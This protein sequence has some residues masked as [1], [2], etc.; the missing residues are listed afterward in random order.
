ME[1]K[2]GVYVRLKQHANQE[3]NMGVM[4]AISVLWI[5]I[6]AAMIT[7]VGHTTCTIE[8]LTHPIHPSYYISDG[9]YMIKYYGGDEKNESEMNNLADVELT[10]IGNDSKLSG[11][12]TSTGADVDAWCDNGADFVG[13][14]ITV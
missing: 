6:I 9:N 2:K 3:N 1:N 12:G 11:C 8:I 10:Y 7:K 14:T 13:L 4:P 5:L